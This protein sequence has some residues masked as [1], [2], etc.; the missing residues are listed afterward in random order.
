MLKPLWLAARLACGLMLMGG[1]VAGGHAQLASPAIDHNLY[2]RGAIQASRRQFDRWLLA[3][4]Q[5]AALHQRYCSL[6]TRAFDQRGV[7]IADV[8]V[9][10]DD[11]GHPAALIKVAPGLLLPTRVLISAGNGKA[12]HILARLSATACNVAGCMLVWELPPRAIEDLRHG[13]ALT[14]NFRS[15]PTPHAPAGP[16]VVR[17]VPV[18]GS[19]IATGFNAALLASIK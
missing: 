3:C 12:R 19:I 10:T 1:L 4:D 2:R 13:T 16:L 15:V 7:P 6:S 11:H 5:I 18:S 17:S 9:S 8:T 14:L